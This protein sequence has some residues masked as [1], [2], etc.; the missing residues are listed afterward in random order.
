MINFGQLKNSFPT[1][2][3]QRGGGH[4]FSPG[5]SFQI[6]QTK[7][8]RNPQGV[9]SGSDASDADRCGDGVVVSVVC[10]CYGREWENGQMESIDIG[11]FFFQNGFKW[12]N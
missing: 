11:L 12:T 5:G 4:H 2:F 8:I 6:S 3:A 7:K 10:G 1:N 9:G